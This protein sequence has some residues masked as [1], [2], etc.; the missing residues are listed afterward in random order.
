MTFA[1]ATEMIRAGNIEKF[2]A[3]IYQ[4][5]QSLERFSRLRGGGAPS[6]LCAAAEE[7]T[8]S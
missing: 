3:Q 4:S 7:L 1:A 8:V 2:C 6:Q 5:A